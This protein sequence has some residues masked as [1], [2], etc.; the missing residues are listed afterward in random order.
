VRGTGGEHR[1]ILVNRALAQN[2]HVRL[3]TTGQK[4]TVLRLTARSAESQS[5]LTFGGASVDPNG[6]WAPRMAEL[7]T[8]KADRFVV[9]VPAASA[10][11][12]QIHTG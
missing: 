2:E 12:V 4:A 7:M 10:A 9:D 11:V 6:D 5:G 1:V 3:A 8:L